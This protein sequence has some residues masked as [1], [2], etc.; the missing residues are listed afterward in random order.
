MQP[1]GGFRIYR[2]PLRRFSSF[3]LGSFLGPF[4][5]IAG[6]MKVGFGAGLSCVL[7]GGSQSLVKLATTAAGSTGL[8]AQIDATVLTCQGAGALWGSQ[9]SS[10][11][12]AGGTVYMGQIFIVQRAAP[13]ETG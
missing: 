5:A 11:I 13:G 8:A 4:V 6:A 2:N 3:G 9:E 1:A 7:F 10:A 12:S